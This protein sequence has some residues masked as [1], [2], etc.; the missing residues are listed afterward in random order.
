LIAR[1]NLPLCFGESRAFQEYI[2][3]AHNPRFIKSSRQ[4]TA[5][6]LIKLF[7]DRVEQLIG[8]LKSVSSIALT[9]DIWSSK[10]KEDYISVV[11][12]FV[13]SDWCLEKRLLGLRPIEVAHTE[14]NIAER[15]EIVANDY[16][17]TNKIFAIVPDNSSSNKI[18]MDVLK[19]LFSGYIGNLIPMPSR[20]EYDLSSIFLHQHYACNTINLIVK[21]CLKRLQPYLEDFRTAITLLNSLNQRIASYKQYCLSVGVCPRKIEIDMDVRWNSTFLKLKHIVPYQ[22][23]F[24][25]WIKT[26]HPC[27]S[28]GSFL[29]IEN[30]WCIAEKLLTFLQL[31]Y[32]SK[33]LCLVFITLLHP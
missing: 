8:V 12:H 14:Y 31:F 24:S 4:T 23:T 29:L 15:V 5:R 9:S 6:D 3:H 2:T 16:G 7:N 22:T 33:W 26:N 13:N 11:A 17:I 32:D 19:P 21:S 1:L 20:N 25:V 10:A 30:H 28:D 27:K 18:V